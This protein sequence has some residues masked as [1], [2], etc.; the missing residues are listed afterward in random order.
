MNKLYFIIPAVGLVAF[1][2]YWYSFNTSYEQE[3]EAKILAEQKRIEL[4]QE[5]DKHTR[6][7]AIKIAVE[8]NDKRKAEREAKAAK[9]KV[10]KEAREAS[11]EARNK[12][13][14]EQFKLQAEEERKKKEADDLK[15][16]IAKVEADIK[17]LVAEREFL[18][19][20]VTKA[21]ENTKALND[22]ATKI[23]KADEQIKKTAKELVALKKTSN[24]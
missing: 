9:D 6:E 21:E 15:A 22:V 3:R 11:I 10:E 13:R 14:S 23:E 24:S 2:A 18:K 1:S 5:E 12:A 8:A 16:E 7:L 20:Y 17:V 4:K 19:T